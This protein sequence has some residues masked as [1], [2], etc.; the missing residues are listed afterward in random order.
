MK[1]EHIALIIDEYGGMQGI[2]TM[3]DILETILGLEIMDEKDIEADMQE[4][5]KKKWEERKK[6]LNIGKDQ[7]LD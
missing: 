6:N 1:K 4:F 2:A 5:A 3:E 7:S